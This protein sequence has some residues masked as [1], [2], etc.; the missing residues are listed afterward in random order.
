MP[1]ETGGE[2]LSPTPSGTFTSVSVGTGWACA[3]RA[4]GT[5]ACWGSAAFTPPTG[6]FTAVSVRH[7]H[8]CA[9]TP[10]GSIDC[11]GDNSAG[12]LSNIPTGKFTSISAG[13]F[14]T[15]GVASDSTVHCWGSDSADQ[16]GAPPVLNRQKVPGGLQ[17]FIYFFNFASQNALTTDGIPVAAFSVSK[18]SLPPGLTLDPSYGLFQGYPKTPGSFPFTVT[19]SNVEGTVSEATRVIVL[20]WLLGFKSPANHA[21]IAKSGHTLL[22]SFKLGDTNGN[23]VAAKYASGLTMKVSLSRKRGVVNG[24]TSAPCTFGAAK[25]LFQCKLKLPASLL[26]GTKHPYYLT[27]FQQGSS[28]YEPSMPVKPHGPVVNPEVI[29]FR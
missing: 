4:D 15:C 10:A 11:W 12:E 23:S 3:L 14:D 1:G 16:L 21:H 18:G 19:V 27:V 6:Q 13:E 9:L 28:G 5:I 26:T 8:A 17:D 29:Y 24:V 20:G 25:R 22:V 2:S 7:L